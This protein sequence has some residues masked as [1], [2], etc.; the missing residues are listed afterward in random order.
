MTVVSPSKAIQVPDSYASPQRQLLQITDS[1]GD[2][3]DT[4]IR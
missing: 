1:V 2:G 4:F 3:I